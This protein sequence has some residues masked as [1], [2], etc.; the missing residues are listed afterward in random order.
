V[1]VEDAKL[2]ASVR[3]VLA[4]VVVVAGL[5]VVALAAAAAGRGGADSTQAV[6][7]P[8]CGEQRLFGFI[9]ALTK[10]GPTY[11]L[12]FDPAFFLSGETANE[13]AAQD[14]VVPRGQP[15]PNDNYVVNESRRT[16]VYLVTPATSIHVLLQ[17]GN[18]TQGSAVSVGT[19]VQLVHGKHPVKLFES[20]DSGFW[21]G[22]HIDH[23]C[24]LTQQY[25]P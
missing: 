11:R 24:S 7:N 19:L 12:R 15:V 25:H 3:S 9:R 23:A 22:V 1:N 21:L 14:G 10:H 18:I 13:A 17:G 2:K 20:L 5:G 8:Y 6:V 4:L 16:Y